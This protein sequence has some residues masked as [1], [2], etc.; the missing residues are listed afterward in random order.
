MDDDILSQGDD[1]EPRPWPRRAGVIAALVLAVVAGT[2][3]LV[4]PHHQHPATATPP[5]RPAA[6][7]PGGAIPSPITI[8]GNL[9]ISGQL[10]VRDG[11]IVRSVP[12]G[13][14]LRLPVTGRQPAWYS[15]ATG[16]FDSIGGLPADSAGYQFTRVDGGW[17]VQANSGGKIACGGCGGFAMPVWFLADGAHSATRVG[18]TNLVAPATS[19]GAL[20][21]TSYPPGANTTDSAAGRARE[22]GPTGALL[23]PPVTLPA[24]YVIEQGTDRGLL[25]APAN[26][27]AGTGTG[28]GAD[29]LW[30]PGSPHASRTFGQVIAAN[31]TEIASAPPCAS[32][33]SVQV[34]DLATGKDTVVRL[35]AASTAANGAFSPSGGYL[36]F[37][38]ISENVGDDGSLAMQLDVASVASGRL[39]EVPRTSVSS[40]ALFSFGWPA[41]SDSLVTEFTFMPTIQLASWQ[42]GSSRLAVSVLK[43]GP[44]QASLVVG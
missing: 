28:T 19:A 22:V 23:R 24:G 30:N 3:Y 4:L 20:W 39:T 7:A 18:L 1:R 17:A 43:P 37:Q 42:L 10:A 29:R 32:T 13:D 26:P 12:W 41:N 31:A 14:T 27:A 8:A 34:L 9:V 5:P 38:V 21:L 16:R 33:C 44:T 15:P 40:D 6:T 36:A 2:V 25:L 35:P 11:I